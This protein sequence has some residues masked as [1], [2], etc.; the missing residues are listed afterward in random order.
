MRPVGLLHPRAPQPH[1]QSDFHVIPRLRVQHVPQHFLKAEEGAGATR[2]QGTPDGARLARR[3]VNE[4]QQSVPPCACASRE[5][6]PASAFLLSAPQP[7]GPSR[8]VI[9]EFVGGEEPKRPESKRNNG[10]RR[11]AEERRGVED[12][13]VSPK[14]HDDVN[15]VG[16]EVPVLLRGV[17]GCGGRV[18]W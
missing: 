7:P 18:L 17:A 6:A 9:A 8:L 3:G 4:P 2:E 5:A 15:D 1:P 12:D 10:R 16:G 14:A 13:A 11:L